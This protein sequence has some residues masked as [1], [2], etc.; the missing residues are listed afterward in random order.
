[1]KDTGVVV[2][3]LASPFQNG[4]GL[5]LKTMDGGNTWNLGSSSQYKSAVHGPRHLIPL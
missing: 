5:Y 1:N 2:G 4:P 3:I